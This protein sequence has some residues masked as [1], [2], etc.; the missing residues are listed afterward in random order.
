[1]GQTQVITFAQFVELF[2]VTGALI[3]RI[4]EQR[5]NQHTIRRAQITQTERTRLQTPSGAQN[6]TKLFTGPF[7]YWKKEG[8]IWN[9]D[10][11][12]SAQT[13]PQS[14]LFLYETT[15]IMIDA[16]GKIKC[17]NVVIY[18]PE[19]TPDRPTLT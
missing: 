10:I 18:H 19:K 4:A 1:M 11:P 9:S 17:G 12:K 15:P 3:G 7:L 5:A 8:Q 16:D 14:N 6:V 2:V 13:L